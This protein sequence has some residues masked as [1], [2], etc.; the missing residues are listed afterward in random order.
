MSSI[1]PSASWSNRFSA[2]CSLD[3]MALSSRCS[4]SRIRAAFSSSSLSSA[5]LS[6]ALTSSSSSS[7][8][9][10]TWRWS[11]SF[12]TSLCLRRPSA[13]SGA[14]ASFALSTPF[15]ASATSLS[16]ALIAVSRD[17]NPE[18]ERPALEPE[19]PPERERFRRRAFSLWRRPRPARLPCLLRLRC[20][21][22]LLRRFLR[23]RGLLALRRSEGLDLLA[24]LLWLPLRLRLRLALRRAAGTLPTM[25][26]SFSRNSSR[27]FVSCRTGS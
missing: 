12:C 5:S 22:F 2:S 14:R 19:L 1:R 9:F 27:N 24:D 20:R 10:S 15:S 6:L 13:N 3:A 21:L 23:L 18:R 8:S 7:L 25:P 16:A 26:I 17:G 11:S 4:A